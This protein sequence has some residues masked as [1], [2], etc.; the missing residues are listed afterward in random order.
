MKA[1]A[2][3]ISGVKLL[4][5]KVFA[6]NR[7]SFMEIWNNKTF[8]EIGIPDSFIQDNISTSIKGVLRGVHTQLIHPQSKIVCCLSGSIFDVAVDCRINS[9]SYGRWHGE[10]LS[11]ENRKMMYIPEGVAHGY[12]TINDATILMKVTTHYTPGDEIG[13]MWDDTTICIEWPLIAGAETILAEK[14]TK[15]GSFK[16]MMNIIAQYR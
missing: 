3:N 13:F 5:P 15:W 14:D 7:G 9:P 10:I 4:S 12:Y 1:E 2:T 6:D 8:N 16:D 11:A